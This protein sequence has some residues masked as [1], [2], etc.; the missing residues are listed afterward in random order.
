MEDALLIW[1]KQ[2]RALNIPVSGPI[3]KEKAKKLALVLGYVEFQ[4]SDGW[5]DRFKKRNGITFRAICGESN[6]VPEIAVNDWLTNKLPRMLAAYEPK[7]VFNADEMGLFYRLTPEKTFA[8]KGESCH[9]GKK[10]KERVTILVAANMDGSEKLPLLIIGKSANPRC[11][12]GK[13]IPAEYRSNAK[14]W[15]TSAIFS[16]W[17]LA[18]D[19]KFSLQG[20]KVLLVVD[21]CS[22]HDPDVSRRLHA[23]RLEFLT[24]NCTSKLQPCDMGIIQNFKVHYRK[25]LLCKMITGV[26]ENKITDLSVDILQCIVW[27]CS[28]WEDDVTS[29]TIANCFRKAGFLKEG[30]TVIQDSCGQDISELSTVFSCILAHRRP[31]DD[32]VVTADEFICIDDKLETSRVLSDEDIVRTIQN[33]H[34]SGEG[35]VTPQE[36]LSEE[37]LP[38][39]PSLA[40]AKAA[41]SILQHFIRTTE[42]PESAAM[43]TCVGKIDAFLARETIAR[44]VQKKITDYIRN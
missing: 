27:A 39:G 11:F 18:L 7:D 22:A 19:R 3:L 20:R 33:L 43:I 30:T 23:I 42:S 16:E 9:G 14:A 32:A 13:H 12:K 25:R 4:C 6:A 34:S 17:V 26:E 21:N 37:H 24:P 35:E 10:S 41:L 1:F 29:A 38:P 5:L 40:D 2:A 44:Q 28:A 31:K 8:F 36:R 15:M